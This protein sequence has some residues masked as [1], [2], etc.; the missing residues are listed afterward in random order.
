M[1]IFHHLYLEKVCRSIFVAMG[2][3]SEEADVV[4]THVVR[5]NLVGHDSHGVIQVP[6]Y[7]QRIRVG[8]IVPRASL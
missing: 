5:A 1:P 2:A 8:H 4:S 7:A 6:V 3:T